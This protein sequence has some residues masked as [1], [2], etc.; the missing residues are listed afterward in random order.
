MTISAQNE[1]TDARAVDAVIVGA[2]FAGLFMLHRLRSLGFSAQAIEAG[3]GVGGTWYWNRYPG[4]RCDVESVEY[5]YKFSEELQQEWEWSE[6]YATQPEILRYLNHVADRFDLRKDITFNTRVLSANYDEAAERW[7]VTTDTG[8]TYSSRFCIMATGCLS[9]M[10]KPKLPNLEEFKGDIYY[11]G[12]WPHGGVDFTGKRVG[13]IGTGS[14]SIQ[15]IPI[16][17]KQAETLTVFQRTPG[18]CVPARNAPLHPDEIK[19][20]KANYPEFRK[21]NESFAFA[22]DLGNPRPS[23]KEATPEERRQV[24][25]ECWDRGGL[26]FL[27]SYEDLIVDRTSNDLAAEFLRG[28]I[29]EIVSD[30]KVAQKLL[31]TIT[32]GCKRLC[33]DTGYYATYNR[34][35]VE[36]VDIKETPIA[37]VLP[38]GL[39]T[40][41]NA[42]DLDCIVFGTGFD[43]MT[44]ALNRIDIR[45]RE[46]LALKDKWAEGPRAYLGL[47]SA[48]FPNM[49]FISG[50]GSPSVLTNMVPS[51]EQHVEFIGRCIAYLN[52]HNITSISPARQAEDDWVDHV[53]SVADGTL[54]PGCNS[55]YLGANVPGKPRIFMAL[56]GF[57]DYVKK[58]EQVEAKGYD[59]FVLRRNKS[60]ADAATAS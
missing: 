13:V 44:G 47:A 29:S 6:K 21:K 20:I 57:P 14:S 35:N 19:R 23:A 31:P 42:Y 52:S 33:L 25:D 18:Y 30:P 40:S 2:G 8:V 51:I 55:W 58:C 36:L 5:S 37:R 28:K 38:H 54:Y 41:D 11:T 17:A 39:E 43:A 15:C 32:V 26:R 16:I 10:N 60:N 3:S 4:A 12:E 48:D 49:F 1:R 50:P 34:E 46:G 27:G 59:G 24:F 22:F 56:V 53:N 45:G 7:I 9:V